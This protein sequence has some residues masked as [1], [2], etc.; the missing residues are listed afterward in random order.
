MEKQS[1]KKDTCVSIKELY[2]I[3]SEQLGIIY[4]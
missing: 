3:K 4:I 2:E 1:V